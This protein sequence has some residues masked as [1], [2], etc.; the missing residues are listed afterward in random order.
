MVFLKE[1]IQAV[2]AQL[3]LM[4]RVRHATQIGMRPALWTH[5]NLQPRAVNGE[6]DQSA[7]CDLEKREGE[8]EKEMERKRG[9]R[10]RPTGKRRVTSHP[11]SW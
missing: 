11:L 3:V 2:E 6:L 10:A 4:G 5:Q 7:V 8:R 1:L 9:E